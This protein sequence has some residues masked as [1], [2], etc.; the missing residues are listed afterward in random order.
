MGGSVGGIMSKSITHKIPV[1]KIINSDHRWKERMEAMRGTMYKVEHLQNNIYQVI[2]HDLVV[3]QGKL[4]ECEAYI[5]L[6]EGG[7]M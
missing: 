5:R 1:D 3:F 4:A 6:H 2:Q 7:Y